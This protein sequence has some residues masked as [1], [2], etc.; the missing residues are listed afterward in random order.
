MFRQNSEKLCVTVNKSGRIKENK[1][2][3]LNYK[4]RIKN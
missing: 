4:N 1:L 2:K 3:K